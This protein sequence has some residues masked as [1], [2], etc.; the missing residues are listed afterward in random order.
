MQMM[1]V[2]R[3][4]LAVVSLALAGLPW[5]ADA[6][7]G[8]GGGGGSSG[9]PIAPPCSQDVWTCGEWGSCSINGEQRRE[10]VKSFDCP[11]TETPPAPSG[12]Q[13]CT[14]TCVADEWSCSAWTACG[15]N[16]RQQR[17]CTLASDCPVTNTAK[18]VEDQGCALDC[19]G[20][21]WTCGNWSA[22]GSDGY[23]SRACVAGYDCPGVVTPKPAERQRCTPPRAPANRPAP[24]ARRA[25]TPIV[26]RLICGNLRTMEERVRC[27][28]GLAPD[29]L[30]RELAIQY[31]PE[32]CRALPDRSAART[33][34]IARYQNLRPCWSSPAGRERLACVRG[35]L[36]I[37]TNGDGKLLVRE[38]LGSDAIPASRCEQ[39]K[40]DRAYPYITFRFYDLEE[41][42]EGLQALGAP[43]DFVVRFV[44][45]AEQ[46]KQDFNRAKDTAA[47]IA[48]IRRVQAAWRAFVAE[49]P[50]QVK[51]R[52]RAE[53]IGSSY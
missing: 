36:G 49:L 39:Q 2:R 32:E 46:G 21:L 20:D 15:Q 18:P 17:T 42:A 25:P 8:G 1:I 24:A 7:G 41:R 3:C 10:C 30:E 34:C 9:S 11:S 23:Q 22:C 16:R 51:A 5:A 4:A 52:A 45:A 44:T 33:S 29:V 47:R 31:L 19:T 6:V 37:E 43:V 48:I 27:R 35:V 13:K 53:G 14:P 12:V 26:G 40:R 38:C 28:I 50:E